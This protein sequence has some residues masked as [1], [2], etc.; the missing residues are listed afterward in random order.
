LKKNIT[1]GV[2]IT[3]LLLLVFLAPRPVYAAEI[4]LTGIFE[5]QRRFIEEEY[6]NKLRTTEQRSFLEK[7]EKVKFESGGLLS[8]SYYFSRNL[9]KDSS[10]KDTL[11]SIFTQ[12][13]WLWGKATFSNGNFFY[14]RGRDSYSKKQNSSIYTG[15]AAG[16]DHAGPSLDMAYLSLNHKGRS[17]AIGRQYFLVGRGIAFR[18]TNDGIQFISYSNRWLFKFLFAHSLP[19]QDN[20]DYSI[21]GFDKKSNN[22]YYYGGEAGYLPNEE[23]K[24]YFFFLLQKDLAR[25]HPVDLTQNYR[26]DSQYFGSGFRSVRGNF[27]FRGE[28]IKETGT[29]HT[30]SAAGSVRRIPVD[31]WAA[32]LGARYKFKQPAEPET[33]FEIA[34]GSGDKDR[35]NVTNT[36]N[37]G[38]TGS[39]DS[40]FLYFGN[41]A[42]GYALSPRLSNLFIF[43][44]DQSL[45]PLYFTKPFKDVTLGAKF[46]TYLKDKKTGGISD[47][48]ANE[49]K[50]F[51]GTETDFYCYWS[52][53]KN[54]AYLIRYGIFYPGAAYPKTTRDNTKY[55]YTRLTYIF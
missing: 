11:F 47:V 2:V 14:I 18:D 23:D 13:L 24:I 15:V 7:G 30:D 33:D 48:A 37:G 10:T 43:K 8:S 38:N 9:D 51:V 35:S 46:I 44:I 50:R 17:L 6:I 49:D 21:P 41:Y 26:Y 20:V 53:T 22:R 19:N 45:K 1:S 36:K 4:D 55:L 42:G 27:S 28:L 34:F 40:N 29:S 54:L 3:F 5:S 52:I 39:R 32:L 25:S 16:D 31:A 12:E